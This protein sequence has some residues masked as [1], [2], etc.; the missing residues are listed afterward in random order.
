MSPNK[1]KKWLAA[2]RSGKYRHIRGQLCD[3]K[4]GFCCIGVLAEISPKVVKRSAKGRVVGYVSV[5]DGIVSSFKM[6]R[7]EDLYRLGLNPMKARELAEAND[8]SSNY[9]KAIEII[10]SS[11]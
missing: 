11:I 5:E 1:K 4:S 3:G 9:D 6:L 8:R 2:L 10:K 7:N